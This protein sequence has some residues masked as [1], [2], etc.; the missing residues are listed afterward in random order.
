M[1]QALHK[2]TQDLEGRRGNRFNSTSSPHTFPSL[3]SQHKQPATPKRRPRGCSSLHLF[4]LHCPPAPQLSVH[5]G[6]LLA[7][8]CPMEQKPEHRQK[9]PLVDQA[10]SPQ[11]L[12][13][14]SLFFSPSGFY[15]NHCASIRQH[16]ESCL[17]HTTD[18]I[19]PAL[20]QRAAGDGANAGLWKESWSSAPP[21]LHYAT[22]LD[23]ALGSV[24]VAT[25][26]RIKGL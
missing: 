12:T 2:N 7:G 14:G 6:M 15:P 1:A 25:G 23:A 16:R 19:S 3:Q 8:P 20:E 9:Q 10:G 18:G 5:P 22:I 24:S 11:P 17:L 13:P 21:A 4:P 26:L